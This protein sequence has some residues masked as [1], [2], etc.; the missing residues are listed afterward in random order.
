MGI[1]ASSKLSLAGF[2]H[3][4]GPGPRLPHHPCLTMGPEQP[5]PL[6][7][8]LPMCGGVGQRQPLSSEGPGSR[9]QCPSLQGCSADHLLPP[10]PL[11]W[12]P[13]HLPE[14][15]QSQG[16]TKNPSHPPSTSLRPILQNG[17]V[18]LGKQALVAR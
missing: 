14:S 8:G 3:L 13:Q 7:L 17:K 5:L 18:R 15:L 1:R 10:C 4:W 11:E 9:L 12:R 6:G 2:D 16:V